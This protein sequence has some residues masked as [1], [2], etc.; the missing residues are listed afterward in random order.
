MAFKNSP[1]NNRRALDTLSKTLLLEHHLLH[2]FIL[3]TR[4]LVVLDGIVACYI[5]LYFPNQVPACQSVRLGRI[6]IVGRCFLHTV[7]GNPK[8]NGSFVATWVSGESCLNIYGMWY[9]S[10]NSFSFFFFFLNLTCSL[11]RL[12]L[13][14]RALTPHLNSLC[15][16]CYSYTYE[17]FRHLFTR[18]G[19]PTV[20]LE[21]PPI[22]ASVFT[23]LLNPTLRL[24]GVS[25][26]AV[27]PI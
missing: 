25:R 18:P 4:E 24:L 19:S 27:S 11:H 10:P 13:L 8:W 15:Y 16:F 20:V 9:N 14:I 17:D 6:R 21:V 12:S 22:A 3:S 23:S 1:H 26:L 7:S 5:C 2:L